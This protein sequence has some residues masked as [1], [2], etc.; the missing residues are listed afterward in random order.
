MKI[1]FKKRKRRGDNIEILI[2]VV[3]LLK[4]VVENDVS[5]EMLVFF[6]E[7][8]E[9]LREYELKLFKLLCI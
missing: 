9:K 1:V 5:K 2:E 3:N 8:I 6:K 7:D 4:T